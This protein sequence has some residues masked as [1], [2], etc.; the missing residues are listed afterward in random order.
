MPTMKQ[1]VDR[2]EVARQNII[3]S[4]NNKG[5]VVAS[6]AGI[7]T[8]A[9]KVD[10]IQQGGGQE[11]EFMTSTDLSYMFYYKNLNDSKNKAGIQ[12]FAQNNITKVSHTFE[13]ASDTDVTDTDI[14][15]Y[16][17]Q[18]LNKTT[19][20]DAEYALSRFSPYN[21]N[22]YNKTLDLSNMKINGSVAYMFQS[23]GGNNG[24]LKVKLRSDAFDLATNCSYL[25]SSAYAGLQVQLNEPKLYFRNTTNMQHALRMNSTYA[26]KDYNDDPITELDVYFN[27]NNT[28]GMGYLFS[29]MKGV[30]RLHLHNTEKCTSFTDAF[31][32]YDLKSIDGI[33]FS[34]MTTVGNIFGTSSG[35][36]G[37]LGEFGI[38]NGSNLGQAPVNNGLNLKVIWRGNKS[39][40]I[41]GQTIEY[42]YEKFANAL[43]NAAINGQTITIYT[44][45]YN[46]LT[47]AQKELITDKGYALVSAS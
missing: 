40:I 21:S 32:A 20:T 28:Y 43:G 46:S 24:T 35:R 9:G 1:K 42:W 47:Q 22:I 27:P 36:F 37:N 15:T 16:L 11:N 33:D 41:D 6:D 39:T 7:E 8:L 30:Q 29:G 26:F 14:I 38:V 23:A 31:N 13:G 19:I 17:S 4:I 3:T 2:I 10:D 34:G 18:L 45:L 12:R 44:A 25:F 5:V